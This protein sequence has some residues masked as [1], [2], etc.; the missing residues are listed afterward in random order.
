MYDMVDARRRIGLV[1]LGAVGAVGLLVGL[2]PAPA[3]DAAG[4]KMRV[5][6]VQAVETTLATDVILT[7]EI[8]AQILSNLSFRTSGKIAE[9]RAEVG[10]HV[11]SDEVLARLDPSE[12]RANLQSAQASLKSA[13]ALFNQARLT[14]GRQQQLIADG[15][16]TRAAYDQ[17]E[18]DLRTTE[19]SA[20]SARAALGTAQE[21]LGYTELR[22]GV[23]GILTAR[24]AELGQVVQAGQ[25]VFT[26]ARDGPRD[27]VFT[28][29]E[30]LLA[31]PPEGKTVE[32]ALQADPSVK[33]VGSVR[34]ISP[35]VDP[36]SGTVKV[37]IGLKETPDRM[38]LGAS[39]VGSGKF[40]PERTVVIPW[41][42]LFRTAS[43]P[44]VWV[45]DPAS[46]TVSL[47]PIVVARYT[48]DEV[49]L[50]GGLSPG[51]RVVSAG[52]QLLRPGQAVDVVPG[53]PK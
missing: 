53:D 27:A 22:A 23:D 28:I 49:I 31:D 11:T 3:Q 25:T 16:T 21:Q 29:Y 19:A 4:R 35:N 39:V 5:K 15:Y 42:A 51:D 34:E 30:A 41:S 24:N 18:Q 2:S 26:I 9:R 37:K 14:F 46:N 1:V 33:T 50:A 36:S 20:D 44:A 17:A 7:G 12:Q 47:K 6:V 38:T 32:V 43:E 8:E 40:R 52:V 13:E 10:Q 48:Q 45:L